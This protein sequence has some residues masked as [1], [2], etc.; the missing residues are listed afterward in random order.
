MDAREFLVKWYPNVEDALWFAG[1][2]E[3]CVKDLASIG[4]TKEE[5][6]AADEPAKT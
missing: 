6:E 4:I 1:A 2:P 5:V 3:E